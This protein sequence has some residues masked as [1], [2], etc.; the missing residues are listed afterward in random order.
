MPPL[1]APT[2]LFDLEATKFIATKFYN[3][4]F[5]KTLNMSKDLL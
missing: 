2:H 3:C 5:L 1:I 4:Q